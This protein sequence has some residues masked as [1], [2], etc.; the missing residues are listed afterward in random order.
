M[1]KMLHLSVSP[2]A[3]CGRSTTTIM[4]DVLIALAP[5][6]VAGV[7][8]FCCRLSKKRNRHMP[9]TY[10][11]SPYLLIKK[12]ILPELSLHQ[13]CHRRERCGRC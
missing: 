11:D 3:H 13:L 10:A 7:V 1:D 8:I 6:T 5:A 12:I 2:H 9:V 4:R